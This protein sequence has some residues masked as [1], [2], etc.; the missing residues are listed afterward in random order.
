MPDTLNNPQ[1]F[2]LGLSGGSGAGKTF[3]AQRLQEHLAPIRSL[4]L[5]QDCY[6][7]DQSQIPLAERSKCN[8]D[9]PNAIDFA[10]LIRNLL[11]LKL[12]REIQRP[13]YNF[14]LHTRAAEACCVAPAP[15]II[16]DGILIFN[17]EQLQKLF[18]L[19]IYVETPADVRL[20]RRLQRDVQERGRSVDSVITQYQE[21]VRP[22]HAQF[23]ESVK[24]RAD[25][26]ITGTGNLQIF[27]EIL[28][29]WIRS[30]LR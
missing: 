13:V 18:D 29:T 27:A 17:H 22:M 4:I 14:A 11:D 25:I 16:V 8:Y 9:E 10:I 21:T 15:V 26:V 19:Q 2:V 3:L 6:Y 12:G 30:K 24:N 28:A 20:M 23:V 7:K 5:S 1:V